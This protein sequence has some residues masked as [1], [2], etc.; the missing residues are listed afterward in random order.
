MSGIL[1]LYLIFSL[2]MKMETKGETGL[3]QKPVFW[4][5]VKQIVRTEFLDFW[6]FFEFWTFDVNCTVKKNT[7]F[8]Q[9]Y[10]QFFYSVA[11]TGYFP[12]KSRKSRFFCSPSSQKTSSPIFLTRT[13]ALFHFHFLFK[14][15]G[16]RTYCWP[17]QNLQ[18]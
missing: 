16:R 1:Y 3:G 6:R 17:L 2:E 4:N 9:I 13:F 18:N 8:N 14:I 5:D 10:V 15:W 11:L 12:E 7:T